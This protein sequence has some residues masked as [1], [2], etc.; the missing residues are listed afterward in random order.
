[1]EVVNTPEERPAAERTWRGRS[2]SQWRGGE[3]RRDW[4]NAWR[5]QGPQLPGP[6]VGHEWGRGGWSWWG[7]S[8]GGGRAPQWSEQAPQQTPPQQQSVPAD[9]DLEALARH[10]FHLGQRALELRRR[11]HPWDELE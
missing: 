6:R 2:W 8:D 5:A 1:M 7:Q 3:G 4:D 10:H 9:T 11:P